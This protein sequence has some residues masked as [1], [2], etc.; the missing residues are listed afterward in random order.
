MTRLHAFLREH[1]EEILREWETFA[2]S[3]PASEDMDVAALRD[4]AKEMLLVIA[5]DLETAQTPKEASDKSKGKSDA[6]HAGPATAAQEHGA[7]RAGSGFTIAQMLA[8]LRALRASV[9]RLWTKH[10]PSLAETDVQDM[11]RF[12]EAIDQAIAESVMQYSQ[13]IGQSKERFLAILGHDLR[14]PIGAITMSAAF[15][16]DTGE[17]TEQQRMLISRIGNSARRM[18][19][20]VNDLLDF[21]RTRF[22]DT[23]PITRA[24]MDATRLVQDVVTEVASR[25]PDREI[26]VD[27]A[28]EVRG[29][30]DYARLTQ[31]LTNLVANAVQHGAKESRITVAAR[32]TPNEALISVQNAGPVIPEE[33]LRKIF[34]P[35]LDGTEGQKSDEHLGL[36]LYIVDRIVAAHAG[37]VD[38]RSSENDGTVF[39]IHLP[40]AA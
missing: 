19:D 17:L 39:T 16:L 15:I 35:G 9:I 30:W 34:E 22:G 38:V 7:G 31:A 6:T 21:T 24:D 33:R 36:G 40:R 5:R 8:E 23:I 37:K 28:G 29:H 32:A 20:M 3:L 14:N 26:D 10:Q 4:H 11:T 1:T 18:N 13:D 2:R 27:A 25:Y 12:N